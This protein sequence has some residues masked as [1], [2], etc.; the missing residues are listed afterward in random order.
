MFH[1]IPIQDKKREKRQTELVIVLIVLDNWILHYFPR[2]AFP[3]ITLSIYR[4]PVLEKE[5]EGKRKS[6]EGAKKIDLA[7][8]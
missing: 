4:P 7:G 8:K 2:P 3:L 1:L 5:P 6:R